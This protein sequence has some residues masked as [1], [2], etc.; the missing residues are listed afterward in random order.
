MVRGRGDNA[1]VKLLVVAAS[2]D[3]P[4]ADL[5]VVRL[6]DLAEWDPDDYWIDSNQVP[7]HTKLGAKV[8]FVRS[9]TVSAR[10]FGDDV[11]IMRR[12]D[13]VGHVSPAALPGICA[14]FMDSDQVPPGLKAK[15]RAWLPGSPSD[16]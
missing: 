10:S 12:I 13:V 4:A 3:D 8:D 2:S 14:A 6:D 5:L 9:R 11:K 15:V 7:Y 1:G 16:M